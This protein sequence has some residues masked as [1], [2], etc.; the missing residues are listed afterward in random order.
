MTR[1]VGVNAGKQANAE[2]AFPAP[3]PEHMSHN[4]GQVQWS[5][6]PHLKLGSLGINLSSCG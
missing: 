3:L 6:W 2:V 4:P 1:V 5:E